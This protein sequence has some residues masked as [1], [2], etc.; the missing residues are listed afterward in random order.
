ML[1]YLLWHREAPGVEP[2]TYEQ[3]I[4]HF[5]RSL[6]ARPPAGFAGSA[7]YHA[8]ELSWLGGSAGYED[9]YLVEDF[10]ALGVLNEAAVAHG[11]R[12]AHD[13]AA[14][15]LGEA[16]GGLYRVLEGSVQLSEERVVV[17]VERPAGAEPPT[18]GGLLGD[19]MDP[20]RAALLR[21]QLV[22]GPAPEYCV[23]ADDSPAGVA[24]TR[25]PQGWTATPAT[26][27]RLAG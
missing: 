21:R 1:A 13:E 27:T 20:A 8:A 7:C 10:A 22:L 19:G 14:R 17:W 12:T 15:R 9:W 5:H 26:R 6:K 18:F 25:L 16:A 11:H 23:L 2:G 4:D 3:A 24:A